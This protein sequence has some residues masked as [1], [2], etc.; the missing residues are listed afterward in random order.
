MHFIRSIL[1][2]T[3]LFAH[4][5]WHVL[6]T[7]QIKKYPYMYISIFNSTPRQPQ[8]QPQPPLIF[9]KIRMNYLSVLLFWGWW[10][11]CCW[12]KEPHKRVNSIVKETVLSTNIYYN[13]NNGMDE[14]P[15]TEKTCNANDVFENQF[16]Y[17]HLLKLQTLAK[18]MKP[19]MSPDC[20]PSLH[21]LESS[22]DDFEFQYGHSTELGE[23]ETAYLMDDETMVT[24]PK[25]HFSSWSSSFSNKKNTVETKDVENELINATVENKNQTK[26][27]TKTK[28][29]FSPIKVEKTPVN[30]KS[31]LKIN[32]KNGG[33]F[34][35]WEKDIVFDT[36]QF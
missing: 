32:V 16:K 6:A 14:R 8:P 10:V 33:L 20:L 30:K 35:D 29:I 3:G 31:I 25:N 26:P 24:N 18:Q 27:K 11:V 7:K 9:K 12:T 17:K 5:V 21:L 1:H 23:E 2:A 22:D 28:K 13:L 4:V 15:M 36:T 19:H 34:E